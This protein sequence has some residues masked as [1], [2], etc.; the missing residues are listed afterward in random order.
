MHWIMA[1]EVADAE[2]G[3]FLTALGAKGETVEEMAGAASC[4]RSHMAR[5]RSTRNDLLDT[6]GTGG[7]GAGTFNIS[8]AAALVAAAAGAA[9][10]KHG[11]RSMTSRSGSADVLA[12]LGV[13][14]DATLAQ[15]ERCLDEL[16]ICFCFAPLFHQSMKNVSR[17][18]RELGVPTIFNLIGPLCN[19]V[20]APFQLL[21]VGRPGLRPKLA[22]ALRML[23]TRRSL[24]VAGQDGLDEL[25]LAATTDVSETTAAGIQEFAW[26]PRD[27]GLEFQDLNSI[28]VD[29]PQASAE[30]IRGVLA[31]TPGPARDIVV[32]NA[33]AALWL[34]GTNSDLPGCADRAA[35]AI[36]RGDAEDLLRRLIEV[37]SRD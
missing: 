29:G 12:E 3:L 4:L 6:C 25:T 17:V 11:N 2:V 32:M 21:G 20:E 10:A 28:T 24:V 18:R 30:M 22:A 35:E 31:G 36:D 34:V 7:D 19:P 1:G 5:I 26:T 13:N 37:T 8:T 16:G 9:V 23:G 27:F 14:V 15:V 33:A